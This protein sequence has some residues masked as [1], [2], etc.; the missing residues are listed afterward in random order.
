M[1]T[2]QQVEHHPNTGAYP[3]KPQC[4]SL[5]SLK[6]QPSPSSGMDTDGL[7]M[8]MAPEPITVGSSNSRAV[9]K[10]MEPPDDPLRIATRGRPSGINRR[11]KLS[12]AGRGAIRVSTS[13][14]TDSVLPASEQGRIGQDPVSGELGTTS[15]MNATASHGATGGRSPIPSDAHAAE[16]NH[17]EFC[18]DPPSWANLGLL[19]LTKTPT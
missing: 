17:W 10:Q 8:A 1:G 13:L 16:S 14:S 9:R 5:F 19:R 11:D 6:K 12:L 4:A 2:S 7:G 15:Q 18:Q 3:R